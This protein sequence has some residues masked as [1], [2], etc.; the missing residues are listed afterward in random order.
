[1]TGDEHDRERHVERRDSLPRCVESS[2]AATSAAAPP[3]APLK[4]ADHLRHRGHLHDA[5]GIN[6]DDRPDD[7]AEMR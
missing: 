2:P 6:A 1:M 3:P 5:A 7:D 4:S